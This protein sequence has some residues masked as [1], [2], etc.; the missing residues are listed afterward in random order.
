MVKMPAKWRKS[1]GEYFVQ[2]IRKSEANFDALFQKRQKCRD[3]YYKEPGGFDAVIPWEGASDI[4]LPIIPE[5]VETAI[6]KIMSSIWRA[7]PFVSVSSPTG[8]TD[9]TQAKNVETF[10]TWAV[11]NDIPNFYLEWQHFERN[12]LIDGTGFMKIRWE[13]N[14]R[15]TIEVHTLPVVRKTPVIDE[16]GNETYQT[17][18]LTTGDL[19]EEVFKFGD[20]TNSI[21]DITN[22]GKNKYR[23]LFTENG[24]KYEADVAIEDA[25]RIDEVT[26]KVRRLVLANDNPIVETVDLEDIF[27]PSR[28]KTLQTAKWVAHKTLISKDEL[29]R[30]RRSGAW[31]MTDAEYDAV[32]NGRRANDE[33]NKLAATKDRVIGVSANTGTENTTKDKKFDPNSILIWEVY[34]SEFESDADE[35]PTD[36]ILFIPDAIETVIGIEYHD[37]QFPHGRRPFISDTYIPVDGRIHGMGMAELLYGINLSLDKT[38]NEVNNAMA[39]K[40]NPWAMYSAYSLAGNANLLKGIKPGEWVPVGDINGVK[41]PDFGQEPL[42]MFHAGFQILQGYADSLTFSPSIGGSSNYRNA[43]RTAQGTLALMGAAEEKLSSIVE[44]E[45]ATAL[46]EMARQIVAFY[47]AYTGIDKWYTVTGEKEARRIS[48]RELRQNW[49]FEYK[50]SLTSTNRDIR[51]AK[52]IQRYTTLRTDPLMQYDP[53]AHQALVRDFLRAMSDGDDYESMIPKLPG[54]EGFS[55]PPMDQDK[56]LRIMS[57]G[58]D[59]EVLPVDNHMDHIKKIESFMQSEAF[60]AL[61]QPVIAKITAHLAHHEY[62]LKSQSMLPMQQAGGMPAMAPEAPVAGAPVTGIPAVGGELSFMQGGPK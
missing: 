58:D 14:Y 13:R 33:N 37:E 3:L 43:P 41:F 46:Q 32:I 22:T 62:Y 55:H 6:P 2:Q 11:R 15:R 50:G 39:I 25:K 44:Q 53:H 23:V 19:L 36:M 60:G 49:Q 48:P 57:Q 52:A 51:Q 30:R 29:D 24:E 59:V 40:G 10:I 34:A 20:P 27:F 18:Q 42:S 17:E 47:A 28:A 5:K 38:I 9:S 31:I 16:D 56:E 12:K 45:Q 54:E 21:V 61:S 8:V 7:D 35:Y 4:H 1:R 26:L